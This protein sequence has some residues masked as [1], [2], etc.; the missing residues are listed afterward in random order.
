MFL[1]AMKENIPEQRYSTSQGIII[2]PTMIDSGFVVA[3]K[4]DTDI[5]IVE[6]A[7]DT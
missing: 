6:N 4:R 3:A 2:T 7:D 1:G 5:S